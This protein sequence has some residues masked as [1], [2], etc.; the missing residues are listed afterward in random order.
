MTPAAQKQT[1]CKL[2]HSL[3]DSEPFGNLSTGATRLILLLFRRHD[4]FN[5]GSIVC[6][7]RDAMAW[8]HCGDAAALANLKELETAR[9]ISRTQKGRYHRFGNRAYCIASTW[10]LNFIK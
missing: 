7:K 9:L 8:C 5:N 4:G 2:M 3:I 6:S 1:Y 10:K